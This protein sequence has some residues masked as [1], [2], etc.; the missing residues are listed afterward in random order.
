[1]DSPVFYSAANSMRGGGYWLWKPYVISK[2]LALLNEEGVLMYTDAGSTVQRTQ[3]GINSLRGYIALAQESGMGVV[4]CRNSFLEKDW[5]KGDVFRCFGV[6]VDVFVTHF[7]QFSAGCR[8]FSRK[9]SH[10]QLIYLEWWNIARKRA[11]LFGDSPS[12]YPNLLGFKED[13][14]DVSVWSILCKT[15]GV[16]EELDWDS[17]SV[18]PTRIRC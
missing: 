2:T 18:I 3:D 12:Q 4:G 15:H 14:H 9:C 11:D 8:Y 13:R 6:H 5:T 1:M 10:A 17:I 16:E 7:R